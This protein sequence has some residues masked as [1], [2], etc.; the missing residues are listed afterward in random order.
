MQAFKITLGVSVTVLLCI[1]GDVKT[2]TA[3]VS[4]LKIENNSLS[5]SPNLTIE[6]VP[7][8]HLDF[9][10]TDDL[11]RFKRKAGAKSGNKAR[12]GKKHDDN[13]E[14]SGNSNDDE[15]AYHVRYETKFGKSLLVI[16]FISS[17]L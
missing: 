2:E 5:P 15:D 10:T 4:F 13:I 9:L 8:E 16:L 6:A 1:S 17:T 3:P 12:S 14:G 11:T 7:S